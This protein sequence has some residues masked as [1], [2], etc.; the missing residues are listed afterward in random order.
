MPTSDRQGP[1][2]TSISNLQ[3]EDSGECWRSD[4]LG[5]SQMQVIPVPNF[6]PSRTVV[7]IPGPCCSGLKMILELSRDHQGIVPKPEIKFWYCI[8]QGYETQE[9]W[10]SETTGKSD[11]SESM[12]FRYIPDMINLAFFYMKGKD[13]RYAT[14]FKYVYI[15]KLY[16]SSIEAWTRLK[17]WK[18]IRFIG[19]LWCPCKKHFFVIKNLVA[20]FGYQYFVNEYCKT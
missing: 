3:W 18:V 9:F 10:R 6:Q 7:Q 4:D 16:V 13:Q 8:T 17:Y 15:L 5:L 19:K 11:S 20:N 1:I 14:V 12:T 2:G